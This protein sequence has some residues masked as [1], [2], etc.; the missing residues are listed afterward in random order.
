MALQTFLLIIGMVELLLAVLLLFIV[1]QLLWLL[2]VILLGVVIQLLLLL[3]VVHGWRH[4]DFIIH[5]E[6]ISKS[7]RPTFTAS[8]PKY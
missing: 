2:A 7:M 6:T 3:A 5:D 4:I 1:V 8:P